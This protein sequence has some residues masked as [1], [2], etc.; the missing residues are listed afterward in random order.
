MRDPSALPEVEEKRP[1]PLSDEELRGILDNEIRQA[2][3]YRGSEIA[4]AQERAI[5]YYEGKPFGNEVEGSSQVVLRDMAETVDWAMPALMRAIFYTGE[6]VRYEDRTPEGDARGIGRQMTK[7]IPELFREKLNGFRVVYDWAKAG[8]MEKFATVKFWIEEVREPLI[9][10]YEGLTEDALVRLLTDPDIEPIDQSSRVAALPDPQ[11]GQPALDAG[12]D[13]VLIELF[14]LRVK[15][16]RTYKRMRLGTIP[17]EE[18]LCSRRAKCLDQT[19]PFVAHRRYVT[20]SE[21]HSLGIPWERLERIATS[22]RT[23]DDDGRAIERFEDEDTGITQSGRKDPASQ[24]I[25]F[26]ESFLLVDYDGDGF[27]ERRRALSVGDE[28]QE[29]LDHDY[30]PMHTFAGWA[31][32]PMPHKMYGQSYADVTS[33]LQQIRSTLARQLLD[34]IY[35]MNNARHK[36]R[37]EDVDL[38]SYLAADPGHPVLVESMDAIEPLEVPPLP[39]W[40]FEALAYF[41]KVREQRTGIHPYSQEVY[42]AGQNQT[43]QGV[44]QV[45]EAAMAQ[46]QLLSQ[47]LGAGLEDL[48]RLIPRVMRESGMGADRI[49]VG[50]EWVEYNPQDWPDDMRVSVQVGLSP[51]QTEQRIQRLM[52]LLGLQREALQE[53]GPGYMVT[54]EQLYGTAVRIVEQSGFVSP[55]AFFESPQGKELPQKPPDP[56]QIKQE[57]NAKNLQ[58]QRQLDLMKQE[59]AQETERRTLDI[60]QEAERLQHERELLRI[61]MEERSARYRADRQFEAAQLQARAMEE[62][63]DGSEDAGS[64]AGEDD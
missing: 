1:D 61:E 52:M 43:A 21:V 45:F 55:G 8:L 50:D 64:S 22:N 28:S 54:P 48:F 46:I 12:G 4:N 10:R 57:V 32:M 63:E 16:W 19:I 58:A 51:G 56:E 17:P 15:H 20:K 36:I 49:K 60:R 9:E 25:R 62:R 3:N 14:D 24:T 31:P 2:V 34:N 7:V 27:A 38:D 33:D 5:E 6:I 53:F 29:L 39:T 18:F 26:T 44:S 30:A 23:I 35:R 42:A 11:T 47:M 59:L 41:E 13:P 40:A 37:I